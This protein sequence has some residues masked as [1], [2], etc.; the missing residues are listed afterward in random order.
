MSGPEA[1]GEQWNVSRWPDQIVMGVIVGLVL[2]PPFLVGSV[3][4]WAFASIE[5]LVLVTVVLWMS[6]AMTGRLNLPR[7]RRCDNHGAILPV[8]LFLAI[9]A[10]QLAPLPP[11]LLKIVSPAT[12]NIY[13]QSLQGWPQHSADST[14]ATTALAA[15]PNNS[16]SDVNT[17]RAESLDKRDGD[18]PQTNTWLTISLAP[19]RTRGA[20]LKL[21]AMT[22]LLSLVTFYPFASP[23][24]NEGN[25]WFLR[26]LAVGILVTG[27]MIAVVGLLQRETWNGKLLWFITPYGDLT[28]SGGAL[29]VRGPF[30]DPDH[31]ANYLSMIMPLA[32][33]GTLWP[34]VVG[35]PHSGYAFRVFSGLTV[36]LLAAALLMS[37]SRGALLGTLVGLFVLLIVLLRVKNLERAVSVVSIQKILL[38]LLGASSVIVLGFLLAGH[39][40]QGHVDLRLYHQ[41]GSNELSRDSRPHVWRDTLKLVRD[42]PFTGVGLGSYSEIFPRYQRPPWSPFVWDATH[43]DYLQIVAETGL[44]GAAMMVM[45]G[46]IIS[47]RMAKA[48]SRLPLRNVLLLAG[49]IAGVSATLFHELV[50]F[51]LQIPANAILFIIMLGA[52]LRLTMFGGAPRLANR[53]QNQVWAG[54]ISIFALLLLIPVCRQGWVP[55]P[56]NIMAPDN[57]NKARQLVLKYPARAQTHLLLLTVAGGALGLPAALDESKRAVW[58]DPTN[59][60]ANDIEAGLLLQMG[61]ASEGREALARSIQMAPVLKYHSYLQPR[62]KILGIGQA[63]Q[64]AIARGFQQAIANNYTGAVPAYGNLLD[65]LGRFTD[66][67]ALYH[68]AGNTETNRQRKVSLLIQAGKAYA[69]AGQ[70]S[71]AED[72]LKRALTADPAD[73][74]PYVQLCDLVYRPERQTSRARELIK[75]G[76]GADADP[77]SLYKALARVNEAAGETNQAIANLALALTYKPSDSATNA[78]LAG[79]YLKEGNPAKA[80]EAMRQASA[81]EPDSASRSFALAQMEERNYEYYAALHDYSLAVSLD[82]A[83]PQYGSAYQKLKQRIAA[84]TPSEDK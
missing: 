31:F 5:F 7:P 47:Y 26:R 18:S 52:A 32:I 12:Y 79:L 25:Q 83:D 33:V 19:S 54:G 30:V 39:L 61:R 55:F 76:I 71:L 17:D 45:A 10:T 2:V 4:P 16:A 11:G 73:A 27:L 37:M 20:A 15:R 78:K 63:D 50:D 69:E 66:E 74:E 3:Y 43:N 57:L 62:S 28:A 8:L 60:M 80:I 6:Q 84:A 72:A 41:A 51:S 81:L 67:A 35:R 77:S 34:N 23:N 29:R 36:T 58:L 48:L 56:Y 40:S 68:E 21:L 13:R 59:P 65:A 24:F 49:M 38:P 53:R 46:L 1:F 22:A 70:L 75:A 9:V 82:P 64:Q 42:F 14:L 44:T